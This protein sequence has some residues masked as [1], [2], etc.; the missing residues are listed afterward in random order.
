MQA[1]V[2][3]A[4]GVSKPLR[5]QLVI[6]GAYREL[7]ASARIVVS[8]ELVVCRF[9]RCGLGF[10]TIRPPSHRSWRKYAARTLRQADTSLAERCRIVV[11]VSVVIHLHA[12][13]LLTSIVQKGDFRRRAGDNSA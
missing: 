7:P 5:D 11:V 13:T 1:R 9:R 10:A 3:N 12:M 4:A 2:T 6:A 8:A